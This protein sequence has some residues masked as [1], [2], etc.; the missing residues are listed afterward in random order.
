MVTRNRILAALAI[1]LAAWALYYFFPTRTRQVK[2]QF[3]A[4]SE[5]VDKSGAE[6]N[7]TMAREATRAVDFFAPSCT[8]DAQA[9]HLKGSFTPRDATRYYFAGRERF[10]KL[11]LKFYDLG[12][13]FPQK[14][15]ADV[16]A[17]A[18]ITGTLNEGDHVS[19]THEVKCV[20]KKTDGKWL[21][22]HVTVVQVLK[23]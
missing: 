5:W 21:L 16:T 13:R 23:R 8:W 11:S 1:I 6:G 3:K 17:T 22:T 14:H 7:L 20:M 15:T 18:R 4:I 12:I 9:Y 19:E 10:S 2:R